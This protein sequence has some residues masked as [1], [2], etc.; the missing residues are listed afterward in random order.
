MR[1]TNKIIVLMS[2]IAI[3]VLT[4][5]GCE[6]KTNLKTIDKKELTEYT[7]YTDESGIKFSYPED[8]SDIGSGDKKIFVDANTGTNVNLVSENIQSTYNLKTYVRRYCRRRGK[9]KWKRCLYN[10]LYNDTK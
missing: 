1:K 3:M 10:F 9:I 6:T 2:I 7:E 8:W 4:L 5:T